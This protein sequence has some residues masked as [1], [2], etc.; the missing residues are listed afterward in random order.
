MSFSDLARF[1]HDYLREYTIALGIVLVFYVLSR[2]FSVYIIKFLLYLTR[3]TK[4]DYD[5]KLVQAFNKPLTLL[6][7]L[8][9]FYLAGLYL[10]ETT[11]YEFFLTRI[12]RSAVIIL[13]AQGLYNMVSTSSSLLMKIGSAYDLDKLFLSLLSKTIRAVVIAISFTILV[14]EW[15][16]DISGFVAGLGLGGLAFALAAQDTVANIFGGV[17]ILTEKPFTIGD[18]IVA[19]DVEGTVEDITFRSTKV[20]TFAQA[21]ITM[22]NSVLAKQPITNW[23]KMGKRR[24]NFT[25]GVDYATPRHV[26]EECIA[27]IRELLV[28]HPGVHPATI[29]A[30]LEKFGERGLDIYV[31]F[32]SKTTIW[33]EWLKVREDI[34]FKILGILEDLEVSIISLPYRPISFKPDKPE[35]QVK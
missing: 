33:G 18:W 26:L 17:V 32:F 13:I 35:A 14:Q 8:T 30:N 12:F 28:N 20:R 3:K 10:L 27:K 31:Y 34:L 4:A 11:S 2:L 16:Y 5:D 19:G 7:A 25:F 21:L 9:G 6:I 1:W 22:P 15:G 23:T 24:V 29:F